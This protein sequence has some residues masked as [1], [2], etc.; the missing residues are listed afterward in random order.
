MNQ[1]IHN[2][3]DWPVSILSKCY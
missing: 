3:C 1:P 2:R